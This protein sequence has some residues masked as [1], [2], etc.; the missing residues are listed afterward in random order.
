MA[1]AHVVTLGAL[2]KQ[3]NYEL[4]NTG[5]QYIQEE[6]TGY[7]NRSLELLY[8]VLCVEESPLL[9]KAAGQVVIVPGVYE[10]DL[11]ANDMGDLWFIHRAY[12]PGSDPMELVDE[13]DKYI[14]LRDVSAEGLF[15]GGSEPTQFYLVGDYTIGF[16]PFP[17]IGYDVEIV[18]Y[19]NFVPMDSP[20]APMP[21]KNMFNQEIIEVSKMFAKNRETTPLGIDAAMMELFQMR[22]LELARKRVNREMAITIRTR[23]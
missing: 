9:R 8:N 3:I 11:S 22:A 19:P 20:Q 14:Y 17:D 4:R 1:E 6:M 10:Y 13:E 16:L 15:S 5:A 23:E 7:V 12:I 21:Y 2:T 18:Y